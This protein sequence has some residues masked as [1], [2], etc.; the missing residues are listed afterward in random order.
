MALHVRANS[1]CTQYCIHLLALYAYFNRLF[2]QLLTNLHAAEINL[3]AWHSSRAIGTLARPANVSV[4]V[5]LRK[6]AL[7]LKSGTGSHLPFLFKDCSSRK[8]E[9]NKNNEKN[10]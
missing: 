8:L 2:S 3:P 7:S 9:E 6:H 1:S 10:W 5:C 4:A